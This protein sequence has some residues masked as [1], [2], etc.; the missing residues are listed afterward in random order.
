MSPSVEEGDRV[1]AGGAIGAGDGT[2]TATGASVGAGCGGG[3]AVGI[4][5]TIGGFATTGVALGA[6]AAGEIAVGAGVSPIAAA[7]WLTAGDSYGEKRS[8]A[9]K[10]SADPTRT[11]PP[12]IRY[13]RAFP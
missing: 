10:T 12:M 8:T 9:A 3:A 13:K 5:V 2:G 4:E 7:R 6:E 1:E 11:T